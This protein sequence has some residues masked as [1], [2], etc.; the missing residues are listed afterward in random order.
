M[1]DTYTPC[2]PA[3]VAA[4]CTCGA[5]QIITSR[6]HLV[7]NVMLI[8]HITKRLQKIQTAKLHLTA[9][10]KRCQNGARAVSE[11][12]LEYLLI[13]VDSMLGFGVWGCGL[14]LQCQHL[15]AVLLL[16]VW[17][18]VSSQHACRAAWWPLRPSYQRGRK[19]SKGRWRA[20]APPRG[21]PSC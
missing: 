7:S 20:G 8:K 2:Y 9:E 16:L 3:I 13:R 17:S 19:V 1:V 21:F 14:H 18:G 4:D 12:I 10:R 5:V 11:Q 6:H 15:A